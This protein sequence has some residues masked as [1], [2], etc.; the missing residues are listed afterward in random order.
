MRECGLGTPATRAAVIEILLKREYVVRDGKSLKATDKGVALIDV[1]H[2]N[3]KSPAMTGEWEAKL[4]HIERGTGDF[5]AFMN[6]IEKYVHDVVESVR[7][8][9]SG[10]ATP[11][12]S[13]A[14][15]SVR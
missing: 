14:V 12:A 8:S 11:D 2:G 4:A 13:R 15:S 1:V 7:A 10:P 9:P 3:V 5:D 6:G